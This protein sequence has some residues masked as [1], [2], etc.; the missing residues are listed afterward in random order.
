MSK[1]TNGC[2]AINKSFRFCDLECF[3]GHM[4]DTYWLSCKQSFLPFFKYWLIIVG[5]KGDIFL[6]PFALFIYR[7]IKVF[8][9]KLRNISKIIYILRVV[10]F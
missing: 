7:L 1:S 10:W 6:S 3:Y 2:L 9:T 5:I 4:D 8:K